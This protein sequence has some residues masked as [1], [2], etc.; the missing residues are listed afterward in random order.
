MGWE[1]GRLRACARCCFSIV[2]WDEEGGI[3]VAF[4][5]GVWD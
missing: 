1:V 2:A 3:A 5:G 4:W